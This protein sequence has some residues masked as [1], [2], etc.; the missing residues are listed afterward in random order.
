M[1]PSIDPASLPAYAL[2][3]LSAL[4]EAGYEAWIVG[5]W[6]RDALRGDPAHDV[7][8]T[9]IAPWQTTERV[10][11]A[12]G[13]EVHETGTAH[14]T[15]TAVVSGKPIECTTYRVEGAY[16]DFRHPDSVSFVQDVRE[17]LARRDFTINAMAW[18]PARGLLDP[19]GGA[20]DLAAGIVRCVG[21]PQRRFG[22]DAL[23]ILRAIR[24][25]ARFGF[26]IE[27][28]TEAALASCA[29]ELAH[30]TRER[31]GQELQGILGSGRAGWAL[32]AEPSVLVAAVP[33]LA[34]L[35]QEQWKESAC[36]LES[37][38]ALSGGVASDLLRWAALLSAVPPKA[39]SKAMR[40]MARGTELAG[41]VAVLLGELAELRKGQA[42]AWDRGA[43]HALLARLEQKAPH[44]GR[45]LIF[46]LAT[47]GQAEI[48]AAKAVGEREPFPGT[49][50]AS[51]DAIRSHARLLIAE[52]APLKIQELAIS[53]AEVMEMAGLGPG[54]EVGQV[55]KS[56][57]DEVLAGTLP[58]EADALAKAVAERCVR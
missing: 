47:L 57:F 25:A 58:N 46:S 10:L 13:I 44:E 11:E 6:V 34:S 40:K 7:D 22:E 42:A 54:P 29:P 31:I 9:T 45:S 28:A 17:D 48:C 41:Q 20:Q 1:P 51:F 23:R 27:P 43:V 53:G 2:K 5:G 39:A 15:V 30:I 36:T 3:V 12:A 14:G 21:D 24:F 49:G 26:A 19:F 35:S 56:L 32:E 38:E 33:E 18:H 52:K 8:I 4:E 37:A 55:L 50:C 16:S